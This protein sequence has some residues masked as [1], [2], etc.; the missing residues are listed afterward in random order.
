MGHYSH[1]CF[2]ST[3]SSRVPKIKAPPKGFAGDH[4]F[5][6]AGPPKATILVLPGP[7]S[8]L[9]YP[10]LPAGPPQQ[11]GHSPK[12]KA[13]RVPPKV[14]PPRWKVPPWVVPP[15]APKALVVAPKSKVAAP[16]V[17]PPKSKVGP[18]VAPAMA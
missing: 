14:V 3:G 1:C 17:V 4:P 8:L 18:P 12:A 13:V 7:Q 2:N 10:V 11:L 6:K 16:K 5:A 15:K 9:G